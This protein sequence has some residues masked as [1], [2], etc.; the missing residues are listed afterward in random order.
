MKKVLINFA[1]IVTFIFMYF[2]QANFFSWFKIAGIMPNLF[3][4]L[5]IYIGIFMGRTYGIA[6]GAVFGLMLDIF[7]GKKLGITSIMLVI[8]GI[9][10]A[11]FDK[12]FSKDNRITIMLI[13]AVSTIIYEIGMYALNYIILDINLEIISFI[14]ILL[15]ETLY[16]IILGI[17]IYPLMQFTGYDIEEEIKG[18]KILTKYF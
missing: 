3:V 5:L 10:A 17:I 4:I 1:I 11:A 12:N 16:N 2:M 9:T 8:V 6:Y 15:I 14:K 18:S 7:V 13:I